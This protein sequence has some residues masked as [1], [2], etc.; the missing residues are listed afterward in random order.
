MSTNFESK[1]E[2]PLG[3]PR[4]QA[5]AD[6]RRRAE[7]A[8]RITRLLSALDG[9]P[10]LGN[11]EH[12]LKPATPETKPNQDSKAPQRFLLVERTGP[13]GEFES[14][15][16]ANK[17]RNDFRNS[18]ASI[19]SVEKNPLEPGAVQEQPTSPPLVL[20]GGVNSPSLDVIQ[21]LKKTDDPG[22]ASPNTQREAVAP[23]AV[24]PVMRVVGKIFPS[25]ANT[26]TLNARPKLLTNPHEL[27]VLGNTGAQHTHEVGFGHRTLTCAPP[28]PKYETINI[29]YTTALTPASI[30]SE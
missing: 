15:E 13:I 19:I 1:P 17:H 11:T 20:S 6:K 8:E 9:G 27:L 18:A 23:P 12:R 5:E 2:R 16:D 14:W 28:A 24:S 22:D 29:H 26:A 30:A 7:C 21:E 25:A 10:F 3:D 4:D